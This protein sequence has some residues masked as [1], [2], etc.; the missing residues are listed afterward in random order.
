MKWDQSPVGEGRPPLAIVGPTDDADK[1]AIGAVERAREVGIMAGADIAVAHL[2][3]DSAGGLA[4]SPKITT[5]ITTT[6]PS[7]AIVVVSR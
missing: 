6:G 5:T 7:P 3:F 2:A 1:A 4:A